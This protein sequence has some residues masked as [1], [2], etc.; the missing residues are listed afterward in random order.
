MTEERQQ[1]IDTLK[2]FVPVC[3]TESEKAAVTAAITALQREGQMEARLRWIPVTERLPEFPAT[4][5]STDSRVRCI[6]ATGDGQ[7]IA[8]DWVR[9]VYAKTER[10]KLPRW[11]WHGRLSHWEPTHWMPYPKHPDKMEASDG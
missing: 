3:M 1:Y 7:V 8:L 11:E 9:N 5:C 4:G 6:C 2:A 10:G